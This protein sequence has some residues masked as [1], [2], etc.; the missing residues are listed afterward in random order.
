MK[1]I[2]EKIAKPSVII[3][4]FAIALL[5]N[6]CAS[7]PATKRPQESIDLE[8]AKAF[9]EAG[10]YELAIEQYSDIK[11]KYP[12]SREA[13]TAELELA[14]TFYLQG[15][16]AEARVAFESFQNLHPG[17][18]KVDFAAF[19]VALSSYQEIPATIDRD[20][21]PA[22]NAITKFHEFIANYPKSEY[23]KEARTRIEEAQKKLAEKEYYIADFYFRQKEYQAAEGRYRALLKKYRGAGYNEKALFHLG[24][25][26]YKLN[27]KNKAKQTLNLFIRRHAGSKYVKEAKKIL[28]EL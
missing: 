5:L 17:H 27:K 4:L 16:Y 18:N 20:L 1:F 13:V 23:V 21:T 25:C 15:S 7:A 22:E 26:Y 9:Q 3:T 6:N 28:K 24:L 14:E 8:K 11:N 10:R 12:L 2:R 19:R